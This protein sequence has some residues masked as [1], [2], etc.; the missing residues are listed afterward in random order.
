MIWHFG[1][2]WP[3]HIANIRMERA[4]ASTLTGCTVTLVHLASFQDA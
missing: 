2:C 1:V 4:F 3:V